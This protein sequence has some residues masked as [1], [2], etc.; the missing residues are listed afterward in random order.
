MDAPT[1]I[2]NAPIISNNTATARELKER[3]EADIKKACPRADSPMRVDIFGDIMRDME[4]SSSSEKGANTPRVGQERIIPL[5]VGQLATTADP[6]QSKVVSKPT[7][8]APTQPA[9]RSPD[10]DAELRRAEEELEE[11]QHRKRIRG[12]QQQIADRTSA[13]L[14]NA[15]ANPLGESRLRTSELKSF[16]V[17]TI[18]ASSS[19]SGKRKIDPLPLPQHNEPNGHQRDT[20]EEQ[21]ER[22]RLTLQ[23]LLDKSPQ[24]WTVNQVTWMLNYFPALVPE[25]MHEQVVLP[26]NAAKK[27]HL[28]TYSSRFGL[29]STAAGTPSFQTVAPLPSLPFNESTARPGNQ[30]DIRAQMLPWINKLDH[31]V[32]SGGTLNWGAWSDYQITT[33]GMQ[34]AVSNV[35]IELQEKY[36]R[37]TISDLEMAK[38]L[39]YA[40]IENKPVSY[41]RQLQG[42][43]SQ[44]FHIDM[45]EVWRDLQTLGLYM[46]QRTQCGVISK[47]EELK[48]ITQARR[49]VRLKGASPFFA[50]RLEQVWQDEIKST[51]PS[52]NRAC[53]NL[54]DIIAAKRQTFAD[55]QADFMPDTFNR[56]VGHSSDPGVTVDPAPSTAA[57]TVPSSQPAKQIATSKPSS[58]NQAKVNAITSSTK[59]RIP[60][61]ELALKRQQWGNK[62]KCRRCGGDPHG[63]CNRTRTPTKCGMK[64]T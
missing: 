28:V 40:F 8:S 10:L 41:L 7:A 50:G 36:K 58:S 25:W 44:P 34:L 63:T 12:L 9:V 3:K 37:R 64:A 22:R 54:L 15:H 38:A 62:S 18:P 1:K 52:F 29:P 48:L 42:T 56:L 35:D 59:Q 60:E 4:N 49:N 47:D 2:I 23:T 45:A 11:L 21:R 17:P 30:G 26:D 51:Q 57:A 61:E 43:L 6:Q 32:A 46:D 19:N 20:E 27:Q 53:K 24:D 31:F 55:I 33:I 14:A 16:L 5:T 13:D 39:R